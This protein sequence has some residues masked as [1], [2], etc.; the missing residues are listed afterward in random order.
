MK[1]QIRAFLLGSALTVII[2]INFSAFGTIL[3]KQIAV[4]LNSLSIQVNGYHINSDNIIYNGNVYV[5]ANKIAEALNKSFVWDKNSNRIVV[6][7]EIQ[8][9]TSASIQLQQSKKN[10]DYILYNNWKYKIVK[11]DIKNI[12]NCNL[13]Q[14]SASGKYIV[15][16]GEFSNNDDKSRV[17]GSNFV[18]VDD[19]NRIYQMDKDASLAYRQEYEIDHWYNYFISS[20]EKAMIPI[21]FDVPKEVKRIILYSDCTLINPISIFDTTKD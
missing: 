13:L 5:Q 18:A 17:V 16:L 7:D 8:N 2:F 9:T 19:Q 1:K 3:T 6:N 21:V 10:G 4:V 14:C 12:L 15:A 20:K 11:V